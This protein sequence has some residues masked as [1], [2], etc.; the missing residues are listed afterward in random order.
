V[1]LGAYAHQDL[2]FEKLVEEL[3]PGRELTQNPLFQVVFALQNAPLDRLELPGLTL[4]PLKL[5]LEVTRFDL[6]CHLWERPEGLR[7]LL[8]Y[9]TDLFEEETIERMGGH[10]QTLLAGIAADPDC[11]IAALPLLTEEERIPCAEP[12]PDPV[13]LDALLRAIE[14]LPAIL[15]DP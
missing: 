2:P 8:I 5:D 13:D 10:F 12:P 3:Q 14:N 9:S 1:T 7:G 4:S 6:E 11:A 15:P